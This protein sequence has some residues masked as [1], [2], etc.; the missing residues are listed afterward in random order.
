MTSGGRE[1][2]KPPG[3][4]VPPKRVQL[5]RA[6]DWRMPPNTVKVDRATPF[7]NPHIL[8]EGRP[9]AEAQAFAVEAFRRWLAD[10]H[11]DYER[12]RR[13]V[14]IGKMAE[15]RGRNLA[16]WCPLDQPCHADVLLELANAP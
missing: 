8:F 10:P 7:G 4:E 3:G 13:F 16:C 15:L 14:L 9:R 12:T 11:P 5:S 6:K 1:P 2:D